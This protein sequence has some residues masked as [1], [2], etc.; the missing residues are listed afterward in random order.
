MSSCS[1]PLMRG[2]FRTEEIE[3][4]KKSFIV[5]NYKTSEGY[6]ELARQLCRAPRSVINWFKEGILFAANIVK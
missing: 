6:K 1:V 3:I 2:T 4:L 5:S